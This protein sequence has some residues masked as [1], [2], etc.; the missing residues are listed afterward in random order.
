MRY[1]P[2][3]CGTS[4]TFFSRSGFSFFDAAIQLRI[5]ARSRELETRFTV[6]N[7]AAKVAGAKKNGE[8]GNWETRFTVS[9]PAAKGE[10]AKTPRAVVV[11]ARVYDTSLSNLGF[12][13][14]GR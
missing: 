14:R 4:C 13:R 10:G 12:C 6:S 7:S 2:G 1:T 8:G 9:T 3:L 11:T 5:Y